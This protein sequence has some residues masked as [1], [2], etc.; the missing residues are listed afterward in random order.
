MNRIFITL[1][2]LFISLSALAQE[3]EEKICIAQCGP[4]DRYWEQ[5]LISRTPIDHF[6]QG[7]GTTNIIVDSNT[8][9][10]LKE[11]IKSN[12]DS[13]YHTE[14]GWC[15]EGCFVLGIYFDE[16]NNKHFVYRYGIPKR[17]MSRK[18]FKKLLNSLKEHHSTTRLMISIEDISNRLSSNEYVH[19]PK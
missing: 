14:A 1:V 19:C 3:K 6:T 12:D 13:T 8:Y 4:Q 5:Y 11:F 9:T 16:K 2:C 7:R 15:E 17:E 18:Y 10:L